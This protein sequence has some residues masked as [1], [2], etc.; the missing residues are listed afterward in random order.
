MPGP[1]SL[2]SRPDASK[3]KTLELQAENGDLQKNVVVLFF[4][5]SDLLMRLVRTLLRSG[6]LLFI[7]RNVD[8]LVKVA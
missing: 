8:L 3:R 4:K 6:K 5:T 1:V 2:E 7:K